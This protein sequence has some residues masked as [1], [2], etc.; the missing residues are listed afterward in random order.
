MGLEVVVG[1]NGPELEHGLCSL[2]APAGAG[3]VHAVFDEVPAG[4][5]DYAGRDRPAC[6]K[7]PRVVELVHLVGQVPG[8]LVRLL[9]LA[10][11]QALGGCPSAKARRDRPGASVEGGERA[12]AQPALRGRVP[13]R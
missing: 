7:R 11:G 13:P 12:V 4:A 6:C 8:L 2:G 9:A 1:P 3:D 10:H 5:F